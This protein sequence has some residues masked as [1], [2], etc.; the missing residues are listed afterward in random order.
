[1]KLVKTF[2]R[3]A[4]A[5]AALIETLERRGAVST[6]RVEP[7][8]R[9][10][11]AEVHKSG[12]RALV[13]YA[14]QFDGLTKRE[15]L[16]VSRDEMKAAWET[17]S[18]KL[19]AAMMVARA[20]ILAFAEAQLPRDWTISPGRGVKTGQIVR[21]LGSVGC[22]VPGGRYPLPSTLLMTVTPAQVAGV[23][24][25]VVC[26]PKPAKETMA[27]AWLAGVT[28]F[29]R[30]GGAQA[31]AAMAYGTATVGCVDKIVGPGNL[32]V[33]AAKV[34]VSREC[35]IDMPAGPTEIVITSE[36][37]SAAGIAAD[38]V[39]Q[40][41][42]DPEALAVL[43]TSKEK[44]AREVAAEVKLQARTNP[45]AKQSLATQGFLF[46]TATVREARE[47]TNRLAPEHL[48]VDSASD[49]GWVRNAGSVFVGAYSPQSMGDYVSGPNHVLPT[50]RF[51]RV[52]GGLSVMDFLKVIT[53]QEYTRQG[54]KSLGRHAIAL[55]EAE[56]L[57]GHAE[58]VRGRMVQ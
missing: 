36:K 31:I 37:G 21:P 5:A 55:A 54:L 2:G 53:V 52:R 40:A 6:A 47:L 13:K 17:T 44:L 23:E 28:E 1:M 34:M 49:L 24:R 7:A 57:T 10:I 48:T 43:I 42:H 8:V 35:G 14:A 15:S 38:L 30:V 19:Q 27:A 56:G 32:F 16:L 12:D 11:V 45:I 25:I 22:Y 50:G 51:G 58:S 4:K 29:Y 39:A 20:N 33:T 41:E 46:V 18:P 3:G 26:S 9:Q